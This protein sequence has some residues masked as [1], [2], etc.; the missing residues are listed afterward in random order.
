MGKTSL[1]L[2]FAIQA[3]RRGRRVAAIT[4]DPSKRLTQ[5]LNLDQKVQPYRMDWEYSLDLYNV[6]TRE[7]F[8]KFVEQNIGG[9]FYNRI[10]D[11]KIYQQI[12]LN[13]RE[14][15]NFAAIYKME[16][17]LSKNQYDLIILD[18]PPCDQVIEFFESPKRLQSFFTANTL[19]TDTGWVKWIQNKGMQVVEK[20]LQNLVGKEFV[21][22]MENF[23]SIV[24]QLRGKVQQVTTTFIHELA[25]PSTE[26]LL[27]FSAAKDKVKDAQFLQQEMERNDFN[28]DGC[29]LNRAYVPGLDLGKGV[30]IQ[31]DTEEGKLYNYFQKQREQNIALL[32]ELQRKSGDTKIHYNLLPELAVHF[33]DVKGVLDFAESVERSWTKLKKT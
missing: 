12:S 7:T 23:F 24:G 33:E 2:A 27:I 6:D 10:K 21:G 17:I 1:S 15:H 29:V 31:T 5:I 20:V 3:A 4:V 22:E 19:Q 25:Q 9:D 16:E 8:Q 11:N 14:T 28:V 18:T 26:L 30:N 32:E 13:L